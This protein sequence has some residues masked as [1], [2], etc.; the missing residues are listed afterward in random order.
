MANFSNYFRHLL[1]AM[2]ILV[3]ATGCGTKQIKNSDVEN[4]DVKQ[5]EEQT[6]EDDFQFTLVSE[7]DAYHTDEE[8][9]VYGE[10]EYTGDEDEMTIHHQ[11]PVISFPMEEKEREFAIDYSVTDTEETT[12]L[13]K[14]EPYREPYTQGNS[15]FSVSMPK[16]H[17]DFIDD[18]SKGVGFPPEYYV[19]KGAA[20]FSTDS[21]SDAQDESNINLEANVDFKVLEE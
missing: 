18:F 10:I 8:V 14:G 11:A 7:K 1:G 2:C 6:A 19:T 13:K 15:Y 21:D 17:T 20:E 3:M 4:H 12:T 9:K 5:T 16:S